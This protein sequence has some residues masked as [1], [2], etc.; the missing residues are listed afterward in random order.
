M[1]RLATILLAFVALPAQAAT[2]LI[3]V[4]G[5][6]HFDGPCR[7]VTCEGDGSFQI[8][9]QDRWSVAEVGVRERG[10]AKAWW[11]EAKGSP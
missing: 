6:T 5:I 7:F 8:V 9:T 1:T 3:H 4:D 10:V 11:N 2:C